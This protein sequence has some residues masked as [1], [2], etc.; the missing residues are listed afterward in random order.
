MACVR[1]GDEFDSSFKAIVKRKKEKYEKFGIEYIVYEL[2]NEF[3]ICRKEYLPQIMEQN[4]IKK[5]Y[6]ISEFETDKY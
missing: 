6:H 4:E 5:Y 1:C 3:G 2:G